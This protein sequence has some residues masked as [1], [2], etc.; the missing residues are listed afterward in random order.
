MRFARTIPYEWRVPALFSLVVVGG[1]IYAASHAW[2]WQHKHDTVWAAAPLILLMLVLL[3]RRHRWVWWLWT[4][5][6]VVGLVS[7]AVSLS[8]DARARVIVGG[9]V[10]AFQL[11]LLLSRPMRAFVGIGQRRSVIASSDALDR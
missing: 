3:L 11:S 7:T 8:S 6:L 4:A 10:G 2:F 9:L 5:L 1:L